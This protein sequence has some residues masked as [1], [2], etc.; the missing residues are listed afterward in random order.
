MAVADFV[1]DERVNRTCETLACTVMK[2]ILRNPRREVELDGPL[3][4]GVVLRRLDVNP[5]SVIVIRDDELIP[6]DTLVADDDTIELR[7]VISGGAGNAGDSR[8]GPGSS[9]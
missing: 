6:S 9:P 8:R 2:V 1:S 7:P 4:V 5:E 3:Q